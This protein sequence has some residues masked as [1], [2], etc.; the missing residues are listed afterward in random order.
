MG[1]PKTNRIQISPYKVDPKTPQKL[2]KLA[3]SMGYKYGSGAAMGKFLDTIA[4]LDPDLL[5]LIARKSEIIGKNTPSI[6]AE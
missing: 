6:S 4:D 3:I 1:R 5:A 2:E